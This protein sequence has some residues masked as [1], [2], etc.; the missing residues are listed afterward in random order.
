MVADIQLRKGHQVFVN[1]NR[2]DLVHEVTALKESAC[3]LTSG[4]NRIAS[5][6]YESLKPIPL[7]VDRLLEMYFTDKSENFIPGSFDRYVSPDGYAITHCIETIGQFIEGAFYCGVTGQEITA[8]HQ[9]QDRHLLFT[10]KVIK[11]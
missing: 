1:V 3:S 10:G 11:L 2:K 5:M 6:R 4:D 7:T 8:I 9:L